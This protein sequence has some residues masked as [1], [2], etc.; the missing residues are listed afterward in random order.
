M[1]HAIDALNAHP[2]YVAVLGTIAGIFSTENLARAKDVAQTGA[3]LAAGLCSLCAL[4]LV[5]PKAWAEV[6]RWCRAGRG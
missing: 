3:A 6:K 5:A 4:I 1:K 2:K